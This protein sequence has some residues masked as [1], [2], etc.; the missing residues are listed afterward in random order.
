MLNIGI[1]K[2]EY[3]LGDISESNAVLKMENP[4]WR[5]D[6]ITQK[7][8]V[9]TRYIANPEQTASD[10]AVK[11]ANK[12]LDSGVDKN[13]V[14]FVILVTQSPDY[15]L[16]TTAC[17]IQSRLG[18]K[19]SCMAFDINMGCSGFVYGLSVAT[20]LINTGI[21]SQGL[22]ICADTYSKYISRHDRVCRPI[23]SDGAAASL[24]SKD[25]GSLIGGFKFG[26]DGA[27]RD[28]LIVP[29][30]G[31]RT[32][33]ELSGEEGELLM[34]GSR[35]FMFTMNTVP[36]LI[37][38]VLKGLSIEKNGIDQYFFHQAS[39]L[40]LDNI[41]RKLGLPNEKVFSNIE[42]VGNTVSATI[43]IALK[44]AMDQ[45]A[46]K[47]QDKIILAGFGVG[48]SWGACYIEW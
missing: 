32:G 9:T 37:D 13:D 20:S 14:D 40:V 25:T 48:L 35:V 3:V 41:E 10:L 21:V 19:T 18:L 23:F 43:P 12:L 8:G 42:R 22:L 17:L 38:N 24:I 27:G 28:S 2:I 4:D 47:P 30:S 15:T 33:D 5:M 16:P 26:T 29:G 1:K 44:D 11:A 31:S 45:G 46:L 6:E 7:T 36:K 39:R 34:N